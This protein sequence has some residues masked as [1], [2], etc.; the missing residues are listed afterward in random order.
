MLCLANLQGLTTR[1]R[2][3]ICLG[4]LIISARNPIRSF[5]NEIHIDYYS[6][7]SI[8]MVTIFVHKV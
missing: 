8:L 7:Q 4:Q 3:H 1:A 5:S 2:T 6:L